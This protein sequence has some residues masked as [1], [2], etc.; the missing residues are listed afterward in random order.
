MT[1]KVFSPSSLIK[2]SQALARGTIEARRVVCCY[3]ATAFLSCTVITLLK[4]VSFENSDGLDDCLCLEYAG[5][6]AS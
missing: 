1:G 6:G 2:H 3:L 4:S 5:N